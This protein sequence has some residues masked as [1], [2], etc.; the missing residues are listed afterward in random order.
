MNL[1]SLFILLE[2][3][4]L[5]GAGPLELRDATNQHK[6][7]LESHLYAFGLLVTICVKLKLDTWGRRPS[8][9]E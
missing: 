8:N 5:R 6:K 7:D 1:I 2:L 4:P 3:S 9:L